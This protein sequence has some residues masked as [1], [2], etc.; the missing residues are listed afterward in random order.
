[1]AEIV[2]ADGGAGQIRFELGH[3][4]RDPRGEG[5]GVR[6]RPERVVLGVGVFARRLVDAG[7]QIIDAG[8]ALVGVELGLRAEP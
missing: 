4:A 6:A 1:M 3:G 2:L 8:A 5:V 7:D